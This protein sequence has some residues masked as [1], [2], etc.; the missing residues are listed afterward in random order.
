M[1]E[2][3]DQNG[4]TEVQNQGPVVPV[5]QQGNNITA[6]NTNEKVIVKTE[7]A[8]EG[9]KKE[10]KKPNR[11][12]YTIC[13][14]IL[15]VF[16][17][18]G[19]I[20]GI[21]SSTII[22]A[23]TSYPQGSLVLVEGVLAGLCLVVMLLFGNSYVFTEKKEKLKTGLFYGLFYVIGSAFFILMYRK[24]FTQ[25]MSIINLLIGC[26][27]IGICEEFLCR[28]FLLNE[29]LERFGKDKKGVWYSIIVSGVMFGLMHL[30]NIFGG[31]DVIGTLSQ[32]V[33]ASVTGIVFG[34]IYYRTKNIW[35]VVILHA[36]WD[37]S[38]FLSKIIPTIESTEIIPNTSI[39]ASMLTILTPLIELIILIPLKNLDEKPKK[40]KVIG[41]S[42]VG[43]VVYIIAI[44]FSGMISLTFGDTYKYDKI[45]I[46]NYEITTG[47]LEEYR[48][49]EHMLALTLSKDKDDNLV[50]K[51]IRNDYTSKIE[52]ESLIDYNIMELDNSYIISY[53]DYK[54]SYN[55]YLFYK[56][57]KKEDLR[58]DNSFIDSLAKDYKKYLLPERLRILSLY[59]YNNDVKYLALYSQDYGYYILNDNKLSMLEK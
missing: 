15:F 19:I 14:L 27:F 32:V 42:V 46:D 12:I 1:E 16:I 52:C 35:S 5:M 40:S 34:V 20:W 50:L 45:K 58:E 37:F 8:K 48:I 11:L 2:K 44:G 53:V 59:D 33:G 49:K 4:T 10:K 36:L 26:F 30:G 55:S 47:N 28:G 57:I 41:C 3:K 43:L 23:I 51:N 24:G 9:D 18:E 25:Y 21:G 29:F 17:Q 22:E 54:D 13:M 31:Q 7:N 38:L 6:V 39:I 56:E